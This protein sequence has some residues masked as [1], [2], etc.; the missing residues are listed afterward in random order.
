MNL[1]SIIRE[2]TPLPKEKDDVSV[3]KDANRILKKYKCLNTQK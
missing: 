3:V 2:P 1:K